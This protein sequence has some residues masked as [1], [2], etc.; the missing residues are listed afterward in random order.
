[1][2]ASLA[3]NWVFTGPIFPEGDTIVVHR[4]TG[5]WSQILDTNTNKIT[6]SVY[7][8][9]ATWTKADGTVTDTFVTKPELHWLRRHSKQ[10]ATEQTAQEESHD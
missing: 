3:D 7:V 10:P 4:G 8:Y 9:E 5:H 1:M 6:G 2:T